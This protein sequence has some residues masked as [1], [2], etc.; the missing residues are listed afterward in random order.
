M[1]IDIETTLK[2]CHKKASNLAY[3]IKSGIHGP[4]FIATETWPILT[5]HIPGFHCHAFSDTTFVTFNVNEHEIKW[6]CFCLLWIHKVWATL[7]L[8]HC[9]VIFLS[10]QDVDR[11]IIKFKFYSSVQI[12]VVD[13]RPMKTSVG[14][15]SRL[16]L[17]Y[18][19]SPICILLLEW[20]I[21]D[22]VEVCNGW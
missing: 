13:F 3:V 15:F 2:W 9:Y 8:Y 12:F 16:Y 7:Y 22:P 21:K 17:P 11:N 4:V 1:C 14:L 18:L 5:K 6:S 10:L 19:L 20:A